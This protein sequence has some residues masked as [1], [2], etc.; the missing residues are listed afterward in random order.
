MQLRA[1]WR[2]L[3]AAAAVAI[4]FGGTVQAQTSSAKP[5]AEAGK[6]LALGKYVK[7]RSRH[8]R[9][10][11]TQSSRRSSKKAV[12]RSSASRKSASTNA[13]KKRDVKDSARKDNART[14]S[15]R[16]AAEELSAVA[17]ARAELNPGNQ[18]VADKTATKFDNLSPADNISPN[19][20]QIIAS[21][22]L[23]DLDKAASPL[24]AMSTPAPAAIPAVTAATTGVAAAVAAPGSD[25]IAS[26]Q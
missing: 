5:Q 19:T 20:M 2:S 15:V 3:I 13:A 9:K 22:Q 12:K 1:F 16:K 18:Q 11:A 26:S 8:A 17:N 7:H 14:A 4:F 25:Q 10:T 21:D 24:P 23:T 6:P